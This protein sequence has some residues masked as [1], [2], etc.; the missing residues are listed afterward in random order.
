MLTPFLSFPFYCHYHYLGPAQSLYQWEMIIISLRDQPS[1][2]TLTVFGQN[3]NY[4]HYHPFLQSLFVV[5]VV[6]VI[7]TIIVLSII[8]CSSFLLLLFHFLVIITFIILPFMCFPFAQQP[9]IPLAKISADRLLR[10]GVFVEDST[11]GTPTAT[12]CVLYFWWSTDRKSTRWGES[13]YPCFTWK[14][15]WCFCFGWGEMFYWK[16]E[17][18]QFESV[19]LSYSSWSVVVLGVDVIFMFNT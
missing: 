18:I 2:S 11:K 16:L 17:W 6:V 9:M 4:D 12:M 1:L 3:P 13:D 19:A 5:V 8:C 15:V 7:I 10:S 14:I